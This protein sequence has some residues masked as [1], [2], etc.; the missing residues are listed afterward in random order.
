MMVL[1]RKKSQNRLFLKGTKRQNRFVD[2][3]LEESNR[4]FLSK[5]RPPLAARGTEGEEADVQ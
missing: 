4:F 2:S 1:D 5:S 3:F